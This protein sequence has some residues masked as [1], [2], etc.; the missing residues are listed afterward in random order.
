M[1]DW[2]DRGWLSQCLT[3]QSQTIWTGLKL[4]RRRPATERVWQ[5]ASAAQTTISSWPNP[6]ACSV[7][8]VV[9]VESHQ[10]A[11]LYPAF[12]HDM[13]VRQ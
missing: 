7:H 12:I 6:D 1:K 3:K 8:F 11:V 9:R 5:R 10:I 4:Q 2:D 13:I